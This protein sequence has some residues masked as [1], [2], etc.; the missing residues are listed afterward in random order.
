[1]RRLEGEEEGGYV[2]ARRWRLEVDDSGGGCSTLA[3]SGTQHRPRS[4]N[5]L[6]RVRD[7]QP[8]KPKR[9]GRP[10]ELY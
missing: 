5:P 4:G 9:H 8:I 10:S 1:M 2:G 3:L 7:E 6:L